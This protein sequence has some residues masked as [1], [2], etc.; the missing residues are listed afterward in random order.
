MN[1]NNNPKIAV[2]G[3]GYWGKNILRNLHE[4]NAVAVISDSNP[5]LLQSFTSQ[6]ALPGM[7]FSEILQDKSIDAVI[8]ATPAEQHYPMALESLRS[9]K[10]VYVEKPLALT[11]EQGIELCDRSAETGKLL[12]VGH[13][14][15]YHPVFLRVR[16]LVKKGEAGRLQYIYSNRLNLGKVRREENILWSFAPHDISMILSLVGSEPEQVHATGSY[17]LHNRIADVTT[18]QLSFPGG[19]NAHIFVSW[20]HPFKEQKLV[21]VGDR[22]M[23]VFD[24]QQD[25]DNKLVKYDHQIRWVENVPVPEKADGIALPVEKSEPLRNELEHF[26]DAIMGRTVCRTDGQEGVRV[27][28]VLNA[29]EISMKTQNTVNI[30]PV[31]VSGSQ[32]YFCHPTA[33]IDP[34][35]TIGAGTRIWHF[36]HVLSGSVIGKDCVIGQ[37][38]M[39]GPDITIGDRCKIQNNVSIYRG[40]TLEEGV[41]CGPS[42]VFTNVTN[43]RAEVERKDEFRST[44]VGKGATIGANATI[45]CGTR[46]GT[47]SFVAAGAVVTRDVPAHALVMGN[48]AKRAGW[49][50][51]AGERLGADLVCPRTGRKYREVKPDELQ[52]LTD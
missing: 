3:C 23:L 19:I 4:M 39:L 8:I 44:H 24:D 40:V 27:L 46:L 35:C 33:I 14:L 6:Y 41:F 21:V 16:E 52:E 22:A 49:V 43:P 26:I 17:Y 25:W 10:H 28:R 1:S 32:E 11:E 29:A 12:M 34:G 37:N 47:Y 15:Q 42:S 18:T 45:V 36:S 9:G 38:V 13:L 50:S 20:L 2:V 48:P 5:D 7:S 30:N 31:H 51:H